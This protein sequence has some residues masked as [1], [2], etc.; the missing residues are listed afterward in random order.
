MR[1]M[2]YALLNTSVLLYAAQEQKNTEQDNMTI[3]QHKQLQLK[4]SYPVRTLYFSRNPNKQFWRT[5]SSNISGKKLMKT[6]TV[7]ATVSMSMYIMQNA[8]RQI[9]SKQNNIIITQSNTDTMHD[10]KDNI[11]SQKNPSKSVKLSDALDNFEYE[12]GQSFFDCLYNIDRAQMQGLMH[13]VQTAIVTT[14]TES[15]VKIA[16]PIQDNIRILNTMAPELQIYSGLNING[17][18]I[19]MAEQNQM[20]NILRQNKLYTDGLISDGLLSKICDRSVNGLNMINANKKAASIIMISAPIYIAFMQANPGVAGRANFLRMINMLSKNTIQKTRQITD[21]DVEQYQMHTNRL[22]TIEMQAREMYGEDISMAQIEQMVMKCDTLLKTCSSE[23]LLLLTF[24][25]KNEAANELGGSGHVDGLTWSR[26]QEITEGDD[27]M[28]SDTDAVVARSHGI[29]SGNVGSSMIQRHATGLSVKAD[30]QVAAEGSKIP[31][32]TIG[33]MEYSAAE[34]LSQKNDFDLRLLNLCAQSILMHEVN[35]ANG[36]NHSNN[37]ALLEAEKMHAIYQNQATLDITDKTDGDIW[38]IQYANDQKNQDSALVNM[39]NEYARLE[40]LHQANPEEFQRLMIALGDKLAINNTAV[41]ICTED[42]YSRHDAGTQIEEASAVSVVIVAEDGQEISEILSSADISETCNITDRSM[43]EQGLSAEDESG[44]KIGDSHVLLENTATGVSASHITMYVVDA[45]N[46][47]DVSERDLSAQ[48]KSNDTEE[49]AARIARLRASKSIL[50]ESVVQNAVAAE[51]NA[52]SANTANTARP[53][54]KYAANFSNPRQ[55]T[56]SASFNQQEAYRDNRTHIA[57][58]RERMKQLAALRMIVAS[59]VEH[60]ADAYAS[61]ADMKKACGFEKTLLETKLKNLVQGANIFDALYTACMT[62]STKTSVR[63]I[64][65]KM[66]MCDMLVKLG[67]TG[68]NSRDNI[69]LVTDDRAKQALTVLKSA[70]FFSAT[71]QLYHS[72]PLP[73]EPNGSEHIIALQTSEREIYVE[74]TLYAGKWDGLFY[75]VKSADK[76]HYTDT[77]NI[78][79][80]LSVLCKDKALNSMINEHS[81]YYALIVKTA[82][83]LAHRAVNAYDTVA[84]KQLGFRQYNSKY[85]FGHTEISKN[86]FNILSERAERV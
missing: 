83:I 43:N 57:A 51:A 58:E 53:G 8:Y 54:N 18:M 74:E 30:K 84:Q 21:M 39:Q 13:D 22:K 67:K 24:L 52:K 41:Q 32:I 60:Y 48:K 16:N 2:I 4:K 38:A 72:K 15:T 27:V 33:N 71:G 55:F 31:S 80:I 44:Q 85:Y 45:K 70:V 19:A 47:Q 82:L 1:L 36:V 7:A 86:A 81:V 11:V 73:K 23:E 63:N 68:A 62:L 49:I 10:A 3:L 28:L 65:N 9:Q 25:A 14:I 50:V 34:F 35:I 42:D 75:G 78:Y 20:R 29:S 12:N 76:T 66:N 79:D 46:M 61:D 37:A 17:A 26:V 69:F 59:G 40:T 6:L 5:L 64:L 77:Y 56:P